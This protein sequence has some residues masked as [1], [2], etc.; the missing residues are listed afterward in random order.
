MSAPVVILTKN[1]FVHVESLGKERHM[2]QISSLP[3]SVNLGRSIAEASKC[4][5]Q[6]CHVVYVR[7]KCDSSTTVDSTWL[8]TD[9]DSDD[10]SDE[11]C[12]LGAAAPPI[13]VEFSCVAYATKNTFVHIESLGEEKPVRRIRSLPTGVLVDEPLNCCD[14]KERDECSIPDAHTTVYSTLPDTDSDSDGSSL[15][16]ESISNEVTQ[17]PSEHH[18]LLPD[19][20]VPVT[21]SLVASIAEQRKTP[22]NASTEVTTVMLRNI[23]SHYNSVGLLALLDSEGF[24]GQYDFAYVP[25]DFR[26]RVTLGYAFVNFS[27]HDHALRAFQVFDKFTNWKG[28][29]K[30]TCSVQW[31]RTQGLEANFEV[32]RPRRDRSNF[33]DVH[34]DLKPVMFQNGRRINFPV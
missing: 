5:D 4:C 14:Q 23:P 1:T 15:R 18:S 34:N 6:D 28:N 22:S 24:A 33:K 13:K 26:S 19:V 21:L 12:S 11:I 3:N 32:V 9:G 29:S 17:I 31:S 16:M 20:A 7:S 27:S 30:K 10:S 25:F 2:R 8:D